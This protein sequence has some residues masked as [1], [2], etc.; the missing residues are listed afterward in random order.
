MSDYLLV[1]RLTDAPRATAAASTLR[2]AAVAAGLSLS[3]LNPA[4]W[5]GLSGASPPHVRE[6]G[7]WT[8]VGDVFDRRRPVF[9]RHDDSAWD[10]ERKMLARLWGRY[11]GVRFDG[12]GRPDAVLRDPSGALDCVA[13]SQ[14][15][16]LILASSAPDW[17][18]ACGRPGWRI[19]TNRVAA[20]L[21]S[22]QL[23]AG[24][25]L[26]DG[27]VA[28]APGALQPLPL[29]RSAV[30]L[31]AATD[32]ARDSL[33]PRQAVDP[34]ADR[35]RSALE[36]AVEGLAS[37]PGPLA[38]EMSG[39]LDSSLVAACLVA[40]PAVDIRLWLNAYGVTPES[41]E[42]RWVTP[43]SQHLGVT[44]LR[45][46][47]RTAP[48][49]A[50][51]YQSVN[52]G[53]R[54]GL[55]ALDTAHD[56]EWVLQL[57]A[58]GARA[59]MTGKGGDSV[60]MQGAGGDVF[61]DLRF[62]QGWSALLSRRARAIAM[63]SEK[64]LWTLAAEARRAR[65]GVAAATER[66]DGLLP[67]DLEGAA[68]AQWRRRCAEFGPAKAMQIA[69]VTDNISR[70][71]PSRLTEA[72]DVRHPLCAQPVVETCLATPSAIL[73]LDGRDRGLARYAF[74]DRLPPEILERRSKGDM[75]RLY[76]KLILDNLDFLRPWL[77][78]GRLAD[79]EVIDSRAA[80]RLLTRD[81]LIWRGRYAAILAAAAYEGWVR[82][83]EGRL[84]SPGPM[85][86][87]G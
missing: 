39:G 63:A 50:A 76:G 43:L 3:D 1:C 77:I 82:T 69:G 4:A 87:Q 70:H 47:H 75:S 35:L 66:D 60:L 18:I 46:P 31:W 38:A 15:D 73:A 32:F 84:S 19:N 6:I 65:R 25:L 85:R 33:D 12:R 49:S 41:D 78:H 14:D 53:F 55:A 11:V 51:L 56:L 72:I 27:P 13:W 17:L 67:P 20:A 57:Q 74:R 29:D 42:A 23:A 71:G 8:L 61:T 54:P 81:S 10:Y 30:S 28:V 9:P 36:E 79:L 44:P 59:L 5:I 22:P 62:S 26:L 16:L 68:L 52:G 37:L 83:W 34:A 40:A 48:L 45:V 58:V 21:R 86:R 24:S 64:S 7:G 80:D 2:A